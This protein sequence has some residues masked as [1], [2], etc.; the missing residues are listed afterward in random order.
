MICLVFLSSINTISNPFCPPSRAPCTS[1][2]LHKQAVFI[3]IDK[4][5]FITQVI[6]VIYLATSFNFRLIYRSQVFKGG[7]HSRIRD[8]NVQLLLAFLSKFLDHDRPQS[9]R[10]LYRYRYC[11]CKT[12]FAVAEWETYPEIQASSPSKSSLGFALYNIHTSLATPT[13]MLQ[14]SKIC[15]VNKQFKCSDLLM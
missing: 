11:T 9:C 13:I 4:A 8:S 7:K 14:H 15:Q 3:E 10:T 6:L 12:N 1:S 2:Y 5:Q